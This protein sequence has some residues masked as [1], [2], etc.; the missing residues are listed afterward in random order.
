MVLPVVRNLSRPTSGDSA[1]AVAEVDLTRKEDRNYL[2]T[3]ISQSRTGASEANWTTFDR[4]G[5][6]HYPL[7][8]IARVAGAAKLKPVLLDG[9]GH[10]VQ[11]DERPEPQAIVNSIYSPFGGLRHL[12]ERYIIQ[13]KVPGESH[14]VRVRRGVGQYDG[15]CFLSSSEL[16]T[17]AAPL[18]DDTSTLHWTTIPR[19]VGPAA[20]NVP[21]RTFIRLYREDYLGRA[22]TPSA[23]W[24]DVPESPLGALRNETDILYTLV[25]AIKA[26]LHQRFVAAGILFLPDSLNA[27]ASGEIS[28]TGDPLLN[29]LKEIFKANITNWEDAVGLAP[30][31]IR[32]P[33]QA[34]DQIRH[35]L[36]DS[37]VA[38]TDIKLRAEMSQRILFGLDINVASARADA[39]ENHWG[40]WNS[41]ADE[42]RVAVMPD[43]DGLGWVLTRLILHKRLREEYKWTDDQ[44]ANVGLE[45]D[46]SAAATRINQSED[47]RQA[48]DRG[49]VGLE[50]IRRTAGFDGDDEMDGPATVRWV[51][52]LTRNAK[53]MLYGL[54]EDDLIDW[55]TVAYLGAPSGQDPDS[56]ADDPESQPGE[57][58]PGSPDDIQSDAPAGTTPA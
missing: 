37:L 41:A 53:L 38:E 24:I 4:L 13:Q 28:A 29:K 15:Y 36:F 31:L 49:A 8:R 44:I 27:I 6:V 55:E 1:F 42:L 32:G 21:S 7:S 39:T 11:D 35:I 5:D 23:Q 34:G 50:T 48:H 47:A 16:G 33:G 2:D 3:V 46:L 54:P 22:W 9:S 57:G 26:R 18:G 40:S 25:R 45:W 58:D 10:V 12:I 56:P 30:I 20:S 14:L 19:N 43:L 17:K 51:G 52:R